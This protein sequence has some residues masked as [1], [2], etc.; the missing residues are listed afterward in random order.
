MNYKNW[1]LNKS[2]ILSEFDEEKDLDANALDLHEKLGGKIG[3]E[4]NFSDINSVK[5][6]FSE[7]KLKALSKVDD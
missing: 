6:H 1:K 3:I 5:P 2:R 7:K 4:L